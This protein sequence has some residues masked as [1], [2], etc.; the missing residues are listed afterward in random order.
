MYTK[1]I[2]NRNKECNKDDQGA[3]HQ[4]GS[5]QYYQ[6]IKV[7]VFY[8]QCIE[9]EHHTL[10]IDN[11]DHNCWTL[12]IDM[13]TIGINYCPIC[14]EKLKEFWELESE[15][16]IKEHKESQEELD[17]ICEK[18]GLTYKGKQ[19]ITPTHFDMENKL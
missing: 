9:I 6:K 10:L 18:Q 1:K 2:E 14:G 4:Y 16:S 12:E 7:V 8:H 19:Y 13:E 3:Q 15:F 17:R 5:A 11:F